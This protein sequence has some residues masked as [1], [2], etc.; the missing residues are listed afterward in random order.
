M[1]TFSAKHEME[2]VRVAEL[3]GMGWDLV[4]STSGEHFMYLVVSLF[5]SLGG[6]ASPCKGHN[7]DQVPIGKKILPT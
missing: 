4:S 7:L 2:I 6:V 3:K 5:L 1:N